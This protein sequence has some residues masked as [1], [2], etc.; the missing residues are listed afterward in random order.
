MNRSSMG[1]NGEINDRDF[2][3][4]DDILKKYVG[5]SADVVIPPIVAKIDSF[6]FASC[7][8]VVNVTIHDEV[9]EIGLCAFTKCENLRS[10][11][12][13]KRVKE[14][15]K[16]ASGHCDL[17]ML[18]YRCENLNSI[19]VSDANKH[20]SSI[21]GNLYNKEGTTLLKCATGRAD[22]SIVIP[23]HVTTVQDGALTSCKFKYLTI[24]A[25]LTNIVNLDLDKKQLYSISVSQDNPAFTSINGSLYTKDGTTLIKYASLKPD[26]WFNIPN[27]VTRISSCA[28]LKSQNLTDVVIPEGVASIGEN[29]F[30]GCH[31]LKTVIIPRSVQSI[32]AHAF[33][34]CYDLTLYLH[35]GVNTSR[36][37]PTW[38]GGRPV[39][40]LDTKAPIHPLEPFKR[41]WSCKV[42][43]NLRLYLLIFL[44][45]G[46]PTL[47]VLGAILYLLISF[48]SLFF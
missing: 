7:K 9:E 29:A 28:F 23:D 40:N 22:E 42:M 31:S 10:I 30:S 33:S 15:C 35:S 4:E 45:Y 24:G 44:V 41:F 16:S 21:D 6:A 38:H 27:R 34:H 25:R 1:Y 43:S 8:S 11:T 32:D 47:L 37:H 19:T 26:A 12:I 5:K 18:F 17:S 2:K 46:I 13:G 48:I 20:F 39:Y 36:F 3:I 14:I